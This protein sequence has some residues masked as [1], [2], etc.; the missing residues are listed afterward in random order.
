VAGI[1]IGN[2]EYFGG[3]E[4]FISSHNDY[5]DL[6]MQT[7]VIGFL[8]YVAVQIALARRI[9][10]LPGA[11]KHAFMAMF[12]AVVVMDILSNSYITRSVMGQLF[13]LVM[14]YVEVPR[15]SARRG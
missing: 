3:T 11:E 14:S 7:G 8:L 9:F 12:V 5:L 1:G 10:A 6:L 2:V 13:F 15:D 4:G